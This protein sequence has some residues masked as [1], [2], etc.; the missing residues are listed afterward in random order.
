MNDPLVRFSRI[1]TLSL[2]LL[3]LVSS[4]WG[5]QSASAQSM[6]SRNKKGGPRLMT[7]QELTQQSDI[8][9]VGK[10]T[11]V[12]SE[13][14]KD[15][16]R[17][18]SRATIAVSDHLK[19]DDNSGTL[20]VTYFGGETEGVGEIYSGAV[21]FRKQEEVLV[22]ARMDRDG[23]SRITGGEQGKLSIKIDKASGKKILSSRISLEEF[24]SH[25]KTFTK[26]SEQK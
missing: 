4:A 26:S 24:K 16:K 25:V 21:T 2:A 15:K 14:S 6:Q 23:T 22:F 10:V 7:T 5:M 3:I 13:W 9:A 8:I 11:S 20:T 17:I 1:V 18:I 12:K 19:G